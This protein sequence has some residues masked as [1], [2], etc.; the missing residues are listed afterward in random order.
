VQLHLDDDSDYADANVDSDRLSQAIANLLSNAIKFS[1]PGGVVGVAIENDG[2]N[3]RIS[4][5]DHGPGI[6]DEFKPRVFE[7]FAQA[8]ASDA[9]QKG[10]TGLGLSIVKQIV[11]RLGGKVGFDDAPGGGAI[12]YLDLPVWDD[13][14]G[15]AI[16]I[17]AEGE[18]SRILFCARD[19]A[20]KKALRTR[21][22]QAGLTVDFAH[23]GHAA[24]A[25]SSAN[26]YAAIVI[27]SPLGDDDGYDLVAQ[28]RKQPHHDNALILIVSDDPEDS[29]A[30]LRSMGGVALERM[31]QPIDV[32][33]LTTR[34]VAAH[35][36]RP[37]P[38]P[39]ILHV[40]DDPD[41]LAI[42]A[43][44]LGGLAEVIST[45]SID[46]ARRALATDR[47][48]L[49][50]VDIQLGAESGLEL[51][52]DIRDRSGNIIPVVIF[53]NSSPEL[54][55]NEQV[56]SALSKRTA[57]LEFLSSVVRDRLGLSPAHPEE[58]V[59]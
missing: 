24:I 59:A 14:V 16:D 22:S 19:A 31:R 50:I 45:D 30:D 4:V 40:D 10:G 6:K 42:V 44:Q 48:D 20:I 13:S 3:L 8:D 15:G 43:Q 38:R 41:T 28:I 46:S 2:D 54:P 17:A 57:P 26:R 9:R 23:T 12:F 35:S 47:I 29:R 21:L 11:E 56:P 34:L 53:S 1:P 7:K 18:S 51:L 49:A 36:S 39:R 25:R 27:S 58:E 55:E 33:L 5:R 32:E 52:P 37:H